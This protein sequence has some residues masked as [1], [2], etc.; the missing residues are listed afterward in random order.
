MGKVVS[1]RQ[2]RKQDARQKKRQQASENAARFGQS[3]A[4]KRL[5]KAQRVQAA[6]ALDGH[7]RDG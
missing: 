1:L 2:K 4:D 3:K 7:K 6:R 5:Q